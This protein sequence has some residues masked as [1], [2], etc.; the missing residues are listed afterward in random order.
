VGLKCRAVDAACGGS[1]N[2]VKIDEAA[3]VTAEESVHE[4]NHPMPANAGEAVH[5]LFAMFRAMMAEA[6]AERA[7]AVGGEGT[8][9]AEEADGE[10]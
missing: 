8:D 2:T 7:V 10:P 4:V 6:E 3:E 9:N 1:Y 5:E